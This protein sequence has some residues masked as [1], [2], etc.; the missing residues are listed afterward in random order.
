MIH[1]LGGFWDVLEMTPREKS[2]VLKAGQ[3]KLAA[4]LDNGRN[5]VKGLIF[6][7]LLYA[8]HLFERRTQPDGADAREG[9]EWSLR[10]LLASIGALLF[11]SIW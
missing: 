7:F 5:Q 8:D 4:V 11:M 1:G 3:V 10:F 6:L 9:P 2:Q